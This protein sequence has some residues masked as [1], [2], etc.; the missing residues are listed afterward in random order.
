MGEEAQRAANIDL[1]AEA[2]RLL[3]ESLTQG[4]AGD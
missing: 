1:A 3:A 4:R 2:W